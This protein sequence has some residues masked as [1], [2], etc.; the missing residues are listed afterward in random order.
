MRVADVLSRVTRVDTGDAE[1]LRTHPATPTFEQR[2]YR[3]GTPD[4]VRAAN[5]AAGLRLIRETGLTYVRFYLEAAGNTGWAGRRLAAS[6]DE[7][8]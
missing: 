3:T 2:L 1:L 8:P 4:L 7:V 5:A 6:A